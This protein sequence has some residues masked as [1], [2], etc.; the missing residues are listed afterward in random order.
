MEK[1]IQTNVDDI[2]FERMEEPSIELQKALNEADFDAYSANFADYGNG[3]GN[4][5]A[6]DISDDWLN[7][8]R[9]QIRL[10][11]VKMDEVIDVLNE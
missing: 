3:A 2:D 5:G 7:K 6:S 8:S 9:K 10:A 4:L 1:F 11:K